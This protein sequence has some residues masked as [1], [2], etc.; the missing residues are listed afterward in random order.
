MDVT[1]VNPTLRR[2]DSGEDVKRLQQQLKDLGYNI[3]VDGKFGSAT[4]QA[5]K[6]FQSKHG[7][8]SDGVVGPKTWEALDGVSIDD[9]YVS[10]L[11]SD[12]DQLLNIL[13]KYN[14]AVG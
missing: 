9:D 12:F 11:R 2:G 4:E 3:A 10:I 1:N 13:L 8:V 6:D 5:V 7:L 14:K